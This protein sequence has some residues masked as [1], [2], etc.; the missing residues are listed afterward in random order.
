MSIPVYP[1]IMPIVPEVEQVTWGIESSTLESLSDVTGDVQIGATPYALW[2]FDF[3]IPKMDWDEAGPWISFFAQLRGR[4]GSF[5]L[6]I[7]G[8]DAPRSGYTGAVGVVNGASQI[9]HTINTKSWA[10]DETDFLS[11]GDM[12]TMNDEL[13]VVRIPPD[14]DG[15]GLSTITFDPAIRQSPAD[16]AVIMINNPYVILASKINLPKLNT[17]SPMLTKIDMKCKERP[18]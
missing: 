9:G 18:V 14:S 10:I 16:N 11:I 7:P 5:K 15:S 13:K 12:F 4:T 6:P 1:L 8:V 2:D 17:Q 3:R